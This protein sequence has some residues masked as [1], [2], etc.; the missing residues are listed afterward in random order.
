MPGRH[1]TFEGTGKNMISGLKEKSR[2]HH[3]ITKRLK[4]QK[5]MEEKVFSHCRI[6]ISISIRAPSSLSL[7]ETP[8]SMTMR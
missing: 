1:L 5:S 4:A 7:D 3:N 8:T 2:I 6:Y